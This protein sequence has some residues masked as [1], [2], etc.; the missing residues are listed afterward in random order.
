MKEWFKMLFH[1][2]QYDVYKEEN[3]VNKTD[4]IVGKIIISRCKICGKIHID[5]YYIDSR[6]N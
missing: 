2:H 5:N 1:V 4:E 3:I 6:Y